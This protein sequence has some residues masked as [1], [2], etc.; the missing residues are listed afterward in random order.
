MQE[1]INAK[2]WEL[3]PHASAE[4]HHFASR[5]GVSVL[6]ATALMNRGIDDED[7]AFRFLNPRLADLQPPF[8]MKDMNKAVARI[9][10]AR[11]RREKVAIY[12]DYDVDGITATA[13]LTTFLKRMDV[14]ATPYIPHRLRE[15]YGLNEE[16]VRRLARAGVKLIVTVDCGIANPREIQLANSLGIDVVV[17]DHHLPPTILPKAAAVLNPKQP[18]CDYPFKDLAGV[19]I[20]FF[21]AAALRSTM[22]EEGRWDDQ[23]MPNLKDELDL[24]ALGTIADMVPLTDQNRILT[25]A[26]LEVIQQGRRVGLDALKRTSGLEGKN[27]SSWSVAFQLA[28]RL[29]AGGRMGDSVMALRLLTTDSWREADEIAQHL[30]RLNSERRHIEERM[31]EQARSFLTGAGFGDDNKSIVLASEQWHR[32]VVGIV[33]SRLVEQF[34]RPAIVISLEN[35]LGHGSGRSIAGFDLYKALE[36]CGPHL[37]AFGGHKYAAGVTIDSRNMEAFAERFETLAR[38]E[39]ADVP[40]KSRLK[41]DAESSLEEIGLH[42]VMDLKKLEP[43]GTGN[44]EPV[45]LGRNLVLQGTEQV[46]KKH[47]RFTFELP[48]GSS[49]KAIG[50]GMADLENMLGPKI[51]AIFTLYLDEWRGNTKVGIRL[52]DI[53]NAS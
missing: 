37:L 16:G 26:G 40:L 12:G 51:D 29:N 44:P 20:A 43:F 39:L 1:Q 38:Q 28:P 8:Q 53:M 27:I 25:A 9:M 13:L 7:S 4:A 10:Q 15:G 24:V 23:S 22:R 50:F 52:K 3:L 42:D 19:G 36:E 32:G 30:D 31:T 21:L 47:L 18:G 33:A 5:L 35:G 45:W 14:D 48:S 11:H 6:L 34:H 49:F 41:I 46:G 17:S 2:I